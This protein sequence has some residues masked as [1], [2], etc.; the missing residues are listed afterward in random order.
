MTSSIDERIL[1]KLSAYLDGELSETDRQAVETL[2]E[3]DPEIAAELELLR[4]SDAAF[5]EAFEAMLDEPVPLTLARAI[6]N[7]PE[8]DENAP[9]AANRTSAPRYGFGSMAAGLALLVLGGG[10]GAFTMQE[11]VP[12][13]DPE[14]IE[15]AMGRGWIAEVADYHRVYARQSR[16]LVEVPASEQAHLQT[17]LTAETGVPFTVPDLSDEGWTFEGGRLLV[18]D[19]RPVA[20]ILYTDTGG[21]VIA[22][23]FLG[24]GDETL[25]EARTAFNERNF[26]DIDAVAWKSPTA[27]FVVVGPA[28]GVDLTTVASRIATTI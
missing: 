14:T 24:G 9:V 21:Q 27:S 8:A 11:F 22:L 4:Q 20:Q 26:D 15:I 2:A 23:C 25:T 19:G 28:E 6:E 17:W 12:G 16:H 3:K 1:E 5:A 10:I 18:A 13:P 7:A